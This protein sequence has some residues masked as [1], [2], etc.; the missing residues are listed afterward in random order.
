[1]SGT[2]IGSWTSHFFYQHHKTLFFYKQYSWD[3]RWETGFVGKLYHKNEP[4]SPVSTIHIKR[5]YISVAQLLD[6][7]KVGGVIKNSSE[8]LSSL[9]SPFINGRKITASLTTEATHT[10]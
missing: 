6:I 8:F 2:Y 1:L 3:S 10:V 5:K 9:T 4:G 7:G